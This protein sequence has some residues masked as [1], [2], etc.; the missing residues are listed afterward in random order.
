M[1]RSDV[2]DDRQQFLVK[3]PDYPH[4]WGMVPP[5]TPRQLPN[6]ASL[7]ARLN[8]AHE[9]LGALRHAAGDLPNADLIT[10][11]LS[12]R[13]AVLS[14][15]IEGTRTQIPELFE[16]EVTQ[17]EDG[18]GPDTAEVERYVQAL[19]V[20]LQSLRNHPH[21]DGISLDLVKSMHAVLLEGAREEL[22]PGHFRT[23]QVWI[24]S[25]RPEDATFVPPPSS[26]VPG[27]MQE[28]ES[29][30][31]QYEPREDEITTISLV[32]QMAIAHAQFET[33]HPF[34]DGNGRVGRLI[35]P[36]LMV[37]EGYPPLYLS[38]YLARHRRAYFDALAAVQLRGRWDEWGR[39]FC[40]AI[41]ES[42]NASIA[43]ARDLNRI[44]DQWMVT[45]SDLR[46]NAAARRFPRLL[47]GR[48]VIT[49]NEAMARLGVSFPTANDAIKLLVDRGILA[50]PRGKRN[51]MFHA[52]EIL[53]RLGQP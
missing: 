51:R 22:T 9:A 24:G 37:A 14:S 7:T 43:T 21:R 26:Y 42:A 1:R 45:L 50:E 4:C 38:G 6:T 23:S 49:V 2:S 53:E 47:L 27:C 18:R 8:E 3:L 5:A 29:S 11:T 12:R 35:L 19:E 25:G 33:I 52:T 30:M 15:Q 32:A 41:I 16:Y 17:G 10:R 46:R 28:L 13:E 40:E 44:H 20:G 34:A 36:L 31:L 48:P 39:L